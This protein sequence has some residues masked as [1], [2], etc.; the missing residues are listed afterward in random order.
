MDFLSADSGSMA[1]GRRTSFQEET[2]EEAR[3]LH[4]LDRSPPRGADQLVPKSVT[5]RAGPLR[6]IGG[7]PTENW[8]IRMKCE[9]FPAPPPP[10]PQAEV[11]PPPGARVQRSGIFRLVPMTKAAGR[12]GAIGFAAGWNRP[13][14]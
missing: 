10:P 5:A 4:P 3:I 7:R 12:I 11:A 14:F 13:C 9:N 1:G 8:S 6:P 2:D